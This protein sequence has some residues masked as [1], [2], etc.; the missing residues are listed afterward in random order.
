MKKFSVLIMVMV[1]ILTGCGIGADNDNPATVSDEIYTS[2]E[3]ASMFY[4][5][6]IYGQ[7]Y[8]DFNDSEQIGDGYYKAAVEH[9][10][11][12]TAKK[13]TDT[14]NGYFSEE[15]A[16]KF[17]KMLDPEDKN[18]KLYINCCMGVGDDFIEKDKHMISK[19]DKNNYI[20]TLY[21]KYIIDDSQLVSEILC[22][23]K[24]DGWVFSNYKES[25]YTNLDNYVEYFDEMRIPEF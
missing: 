9:S 24:G 23:R 11:I 5:E 8:A 25:T 16:E 15:T 17:I 14:I 13:L 2:F 1:M 21:M 7:L 18:G 22:T 6:W 10:E 4:Y 20:L 12:N 3:N 19:K